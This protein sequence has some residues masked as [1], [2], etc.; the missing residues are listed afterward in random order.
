MIN[1]KR[2]PVTPE[3]ESYLNEEKEKNRGQYDGNGVL[4]VIRKDFLNKCYLCEESAITSINIEHFVP[5]KGDPELKFNY[6][7]LFY[8]CYSCN[9][10]KSTTT[11]ILDCTNKDHDVENALQYEFE[12]LPFSEVFI[13]SL[14]PDDNAVNNTA[15]LLIKIYNSSSTPNQKISSENLRKKLRDEIL[16]FYLLLKDFEE[17][18]YNEEYRNDALREI[19]KKLQRSSP[20]FA[21]KLWIIK[22]NEKLNEIFGQYIV[23]NDQIMQ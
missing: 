18:E 13:T 14:K 8:S 4:E 15:D 19:K 7:N 11:G 10:T 21:F 6:Y 22:K 12:P 17:N 3:I 1:I 2:T 16:K 20:F 9:Q 23:D 5:H